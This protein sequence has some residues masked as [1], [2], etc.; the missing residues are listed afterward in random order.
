M[1]RLLSTHLSARTLAHSHTHSLSFDQQGIK[2]P[3]RLSVDTG[4]VDNPVAVDIMDLAAQQNKKT[5][6]LAIMTRDRHIEKEDLSEYIQ[7]KRDMFLLQY[8]L[9][10]KRDEIKKIEEVVNKE[11]AGIA[12]AETQL[13]ADAGRFYSFLKENDRTSAAAVKKAEELSKQRVDLTG[14]VRKLEAEH[15][16]LASTVSKNADRLR[17]LNVDREFLFSLAPED[18]QAANRASTDTAPCYFESAVQLLT[19]FSELEAHNLSLITNGQE[20]EE[21]LQ[22]RLHATCLWP[23]SRR[24]DPLLFGARVGSGSTLVLCSVN[25]AG[26]PPISPTDRACRISKTALRTKYRQWRRR[27]RNSTPRSMR[28]TTRFNVMKTW[29]GLPENA[30]RE[31]FHWLV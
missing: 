28:W 11:T 6:E 30:P 27:N 1:H 22:V 17:E 9:D 7:K 12:K 3:P 15:E 19:V 25:R 2:K 23:C 31:F 10:V 26:A 24:P 20:T 13:E 16:A 18:W 4:T 5:Q 14:E 8:A 21:G 29:R